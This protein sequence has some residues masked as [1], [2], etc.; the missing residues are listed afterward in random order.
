M[1]NLTSTAS[2]PVAQDNAEAPAPNTREL[3]AGTAVAYHYQTQSIRGFEMANRTGAN[4]VHGHGT[5][6]IGGR[7][8]IER[9][10]I[11][12][13]KQL[14]LVDVVMNTPL[15]QVEAFSPDG[16]LSFVYGKSTLKGTAFE[17][18]KIER[19][20]VSYRML[21]LIH[22]AV[23]AGFT[24]RTI[25]GAKVETNAFDRPARNWLEDVLTPLGLRPQQATAPARETGRVDLAALLKD[26]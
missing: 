7:D 21:P 14:G 17:K 11:A 4:A 15:S 25:G 20:A 8:P 16:N 5:L 6:Y 22:A 24:T 1:A 10:T 12:D 18:M 26:F 23:A 19:L 2:R 3:P 9:L 13:W